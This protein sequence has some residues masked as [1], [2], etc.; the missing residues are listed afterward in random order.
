MTHKHD[1][2]YIFWSHSHDPQRRQYLAPTTS[3]Q[4]PLLSQQR[5]LSETYLRSHVGAEKR[6]ISS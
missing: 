1:N 5:A 6:T 4:F 2:N 3:P